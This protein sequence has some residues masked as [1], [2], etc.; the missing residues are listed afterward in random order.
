MCVSLSFSLLSYSLPLCVAVRCP[1]V[2]CSLYVYFLCRARYVKELPLQ[3]LSISLALSMD[4]CTCV[5]RA[6]YVKELPLQLLSIYLEED[7]ARAQEH[8]LLSL[9]RVPFTQYVRGPVYVSEIWSA[10]GGVC[11]T[12]AHMEQTV[13][14]WKHKVCVSV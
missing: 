2:S 4:F 5:Y 10:I 7:I 13:R 11:N 6:R 9:R 3:L 1:L 14:E 12:L 8:S